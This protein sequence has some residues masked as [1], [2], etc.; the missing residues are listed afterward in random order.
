MNEESGATGQSAHASSDEAANQRPGTGNA[1]L[2]R[3]D[4]IFQV[5]FWFSKIS[6]FDSKDLPHLFAGNLVRNV[7]CLCPSEQQSRAVIT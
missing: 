5:S 4:D 3:I 2:R 6:L 1:P 7:C